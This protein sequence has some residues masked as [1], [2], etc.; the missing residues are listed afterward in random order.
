VN[1]HEKQRQTA[2]S[3]A[4]LTALARGD[5]RGE[6]LRAAFG[7]RGAE[8]EQL[9]ALARQKREEFFPGQQ[10]E[11]RSV[12]EISNICTQRCNFCNMSNIARSDRYEIG[13]DEVLHLTEFLYGR[14]RRVLMLQSGEWPVVKFIRHVEKCVRKIKGQF[15]DLELI[16]CLG[17]L[18][19][20]QY[21]ALRE[22]GADRYILKFETA[23][24][25]LYAAVKPRDTLRRRLDCLA[26]V[27]ELGY[28]VGSG[29]IAGFPGQTVEDLV[30]DLRLLGQFRLYMSSCAVFIPGENSRF[31]GQPMGN[32]DWALNM[33][34][35]MR[36]LYPQHLIPT[37]SALER[38][39]KDGQYIGL[40]AGANTVTIHDGTPAQLERLFPIYS[41][42]RFVPTADHLERITAK[43]RLRF[44]KG[45]LQPKIV[46]PKQ[47]KSP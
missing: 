26:T 34:A 21:R 22:A 42:L 40:M 29:N 3:G 31:A 28:K 18:S 27:L 15:P 33:M 16:L 14:G 38:A 12:I 10:V 2:D 44:A 32:V 30:E 46:C 17:N 39:R 23:N 47:K 24:P 19:Q 9:F 45:P 6:V 20:P 5:Y 37:T 11:V 35:L 7:L 13:L 43:A 1:K 4:V 41:V 36:I 8:Q 25:K